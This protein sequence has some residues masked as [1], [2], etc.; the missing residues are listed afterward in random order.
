MLNLRPLFKASQSQKESPMSNG[1]TATKPD[2]MSQD[3]ERE[4]LGHRQFEDSVFL[5]LKMAY[6]PFAIRIALVLISGLLGRLLL[7]G[8][9]NVIGIWVDKNCKAPLH[10]RPVPAFFS[11]MQ[12]FDF[13]VLLSLMTAIGFVLTIFFRTLFSR[14]SARAVSQIYDEVTWRTS[15]YP[16]G[17]F[18]STPAGRIIT[19]FSSDYGNVFRLFGG[20]LAEFIAIVFDLVV[21]VFLM[22]FASPYFLIF[23]GV[24][25]LI[26]Y[27]AYRL[28]RSQLRV[29]RR[30]LSASRSPSIAHFSETAQGASTIRSFSKE[31]SFTKRFADLD[32]YYLERKLDTVKKLT[33]FSFQ[34][35]S[36]SSLLF[37][38]TGLASISLLSLGKISLGGLGVAFGLIVLSGNTVQM[39]F[40]WLAQFEEAMIGVER[41]DDYLRRPLEPGS[42]LP[43]KSQFETEHPRRANLTNIHTPSSP[44]W[45]GVQNASVEFKNVKFRYHEQQPWILKHLNF[46]IEAGEHLG[47]IGSTGSG[48][49]TLIQVLFHLY[50][51]QQG[52]VLIQNQSLQLDNPNQLGSLDSFRQSMSYISQ[53]PTLFQGALR[54]NLDMTKSYND[55]ELFSVLTQVGLGQWNLDRPIEERGKNLS[56]G[57]RQLVCMARCL[58][59]RSPIVIMDE[60]TSFVDPQSE[61]LMVRAT[62]EYFK[63]RTQIIIA[64]RLSTLK[65]CHRVL[66]L[67]QGCI[68][69]LGP[70]DKVLGE[71]LSDV[72]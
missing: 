40:E 50:P 66:W 58:L 62:H 30:K 43:S 4:T 63:H 48:K 9:S 39:F 3:F 53:D 5:T 12:P 67:D 27:V 10:C 32:R 6:R 68:R 70:T 64:H 18:D 8:S 24:I 7:L 33:F 1:P 47:I 54:E 61:E 20:P 15:R 46:R 44:A 52:E 28:N 60:A 26:N 14:L 57:E 36:L 65:N 31:D 16:M 13:I 25:L 29:A 51:L 23:V 42:F 35:N 11:Q 37:L 21:M 56:S 17:F 22:G 71:I 59:Q 41:L 45:V 55:D 19:R 49:S 34:M 72:F 38:L 69:Q 2:E